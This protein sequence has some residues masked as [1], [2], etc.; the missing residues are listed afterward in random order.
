MISLV[1]LCKPAPPRN[2]IGSD[3]GRPRSLRSVGRLGGALS[4]EHHKINA[5]VIASDVEDPDLI[6]AGFSELAN[7]D[8]MPSTKR[9]FCLTDDGVHISCATIQ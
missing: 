2:G 5:V 8:S 4:I 6:D 9:P 1:Y 7:L 3:D